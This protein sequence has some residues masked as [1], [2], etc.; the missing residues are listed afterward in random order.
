MLKIHELFGATE[1]K[2]LIEFERL[3]HLARKY[4]APTDA[5]RLF[6]VP[7]DSADDFSRLINR[8]KLPGVK[9]KRRAG[10]GPRY[11]AMRPDLPRQGRQVFQLLPRQGS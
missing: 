1:L 3:C 7:V 10:G 2:D 6:Q 9:I 4:Y 11:D 8:F 5:D